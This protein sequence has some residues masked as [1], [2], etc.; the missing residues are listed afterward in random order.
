MGRLFHILCVL[1]VMLC[2]LA[3]GMLI[4][5]RWVVD[6]VAWAHAGGHLVAVESRGGCLTVEAIESRRSLNLSWDRV[7]AGSEEIRYPSVILYGGQTH[8]N[9]DLFIVYVSRSN[10]GAVFWRRG[11]RSPV[12]PAWMIMCHWGMVTMLAAVLPSFWAYTWLMRTIRRRNRRK[13][14]QCIIC[15]YD[16]RGTSE[17]CPEC[18]TAVC[19]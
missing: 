12:D 18:G 10:E 14:G 13:R 5:G 9:A 3:I 2:S 8:R 1:S 11:D 19:T 16:L 4:R 17:H 6:R 7:G 15:G